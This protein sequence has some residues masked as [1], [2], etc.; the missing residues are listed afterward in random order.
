MKTRFALPAAALLLLSA[1]GSSASTSAGAAATAQSTTAAPIATAAP[2]TAV[3]SAA[4]TVAPTAPPSTPAPASPSATTASTPAAVAVATTAPTAQPTPAPATPAPATPAPA[5]P[6]PATA[7]PATSRTVAVTLTDSA[8][9]LGQ[10][11]APAGAITFTIT[12]TGYV[13]H[14]LVV[15]QTSIA[16]D[17]LPPDPAN[18]KIVQQPGSVGIASNIAA[19]ASTTLTLTLAAGA[20]VL[21]CNMPN[22]YRD[23]MHVGFTVTAP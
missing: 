19:N 6:T 10:A 9:T 20:Y 3:P 14:E 1:C 17:Q 11:T 16:Q 22:H 7:A 5:T 8:I 15:L 12:N 21:I 2:S 13:A 18:V 23:G 4:I